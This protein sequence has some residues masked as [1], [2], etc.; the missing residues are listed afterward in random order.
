[1]NKQQWDKELRA[2]G[3]FI[4]SLPHELEDKYTILE[5]GKWSPAGT[6]KERLV[7]LVFKDN[8]SE[9][10]YMVDMVRYT[11]TAY[12]YDYIYSGIDEVVKKEVTISQWCEVE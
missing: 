5:D 6:D 4:E 12:T 8:D 10:C 3:G 1:M 2:V 11:D 7:G 9:K